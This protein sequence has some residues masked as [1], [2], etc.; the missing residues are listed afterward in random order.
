MISWV[1]SFQELKSSSLENV[2]FLLLLDSNVWPSLWRMMHVQNLTLEFAEGDQLSLCAA[3]IS[4]TLK[5]WN[6]DIYIFIHFFK[7][8][9]VS[10]H[11]HCAPFQTQIIIPNQAEHFIM[12]GGLCF[13]SFR[14][15]RDF[16]KQAV[17]SLWLLKSLACKM[18]NESNSV[19]CC[20]LYVLRGQIVAVYC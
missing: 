11:V 8:M 14:A 3:L 7:D 13:M 10:K 2:F 19:L 5:F 16:V 9:C 20:L 1:I 6:E 15:T 4:A 12:S 18:A 17:D